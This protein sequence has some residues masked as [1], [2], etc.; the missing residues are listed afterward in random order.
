MRVA[1][2]GPKGTY[3]YEAAYKE[4]KDSTEYVAGSTI[5]QVFGLLIE[6]KVDYCVIPFENSTFGTVQQTLDKLV[7]G[8][9]LKICR[10]TYLPIHHTLLSKSKMESIKKIYSHQEALGQCSQWLDKHMPHADR[11]E[12]GSTA[13][14]AQMASTDTE[15]A[16]IASEI[17]ASLFHLN[18]LE[19]EI[20]NLANNTTRFLVFGTA[21][22]EPTTHDK[23]LLMFTVDHSKPGAL[24][25]ALAV[26]KDFGINLTKID[27]RPSGMHLWHYMFFFEFEGHLKDP[28][29]AQAISRLHH[30][31]TQLRVW[32]SFEKKD[33]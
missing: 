27:S 3:S 13:K 5:A 19:R 21:D 30:L 12:V 20:E 17:C 9:E 33:L 2:L 16:A 29:I 32:G 25:D 10:E 11:L 26:M 4:F 7:Q 28:K 22:T 24:C 14:A 15:A 23:T 18:V 8:P 6:Q 1:F 31:C